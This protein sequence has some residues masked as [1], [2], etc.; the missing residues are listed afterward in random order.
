LKSIGGKKAI[1]RL[2]ANLTAPGAFVRSGDRIKAVTKVGGL[3][4]FQTIPGA[5]YR[6]DT[7]LSETADKDGDGETNYDEW[8]A[9]T[10]PENGSSML[11]VALIKV[12]SSW[13]A[14]WPVVAHRKYVLQSSTDLKIWET[15]TTQISIADGTAEINVSNHT[16]LFYRVIASLKD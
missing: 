3:L 2:P 16:K 10:D 15:V 4:E 14:T 11:T 5:V 8:L 13:K 6:I 12:G 1:V 9:G 7:D